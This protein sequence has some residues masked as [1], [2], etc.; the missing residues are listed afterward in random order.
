MP[1]RK[2]NS[3]FS[4][5]TDTWSRAGLRLAGVGL[6]DL[7]EADHRIESSRGPPDT[8]KRHRSRPVRAQGHL[9]W[10]HA[11]RTTTARPRWRSC[12][13]P[14]PPDRD[15]WLG[16]AALCRA[17]GRR[18]SPRTRRRPRPRHRWRR[19][20]RAGSRCPRADFCDR[21][22][23][24]DAQR[25]LGAEVARSTSYGNGEPAALGRGVRDISHEFG[26]TWTAA[27]GT[28]ARAWVFAPPITLARAGQ[29]TS[30][31][32]GSGCRAV[33]GAPPFGSPTTAVRCRDAGTGA[34]GLQ[35][36]VR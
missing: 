32:T 30:A 35:R 7:L 19:S 5:S 34:G 1:T 29:L 28:R 15:S 25:A 3:P 36:P 2:T 13:W 11:R 16:L 6:G 14:W 9:D 33:P 31:A 24:A 10:A 4:T 12:S 22:P 20:T 23:P 8:A 21:V 17:T 26:C 18:P 27:D